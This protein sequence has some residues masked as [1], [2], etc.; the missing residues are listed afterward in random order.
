MARWKYGSD[1]QLY[2]DQ[3]DDGPDQGT[4]SPEQLASQGTSQPTAPTSQPTDW[5][6]YATDVSTSQNP[7]APGGAQYN[8]YGPGGSSDN[9]TGWGD[10][11]DYSAPEAGYYADGKIHTMQYTAAQGAFDDAYNNYWAPDRAQVLASLRYGAG[12]KSVTFD[13]AQRSDNTGI[14]GGA[15][16]QPAQS[17]NYGQAPLG[18]DATKWADP[19]QGTSNKYI[20]GRILAGG[21]TI[22]QA[23]QAVGAKVISPDKIQ[24]PDGFIADV[25]Y[26][27]GGPQ[28]RVQYTQ[29]GGESP[30]GTSGA[31][32]GASGMGGIG[33]AATGGMFGSGASSSGLSNLFGG[34]EAKTL[35]DLLMSRAT[36]S[37]NP[38][39]KNPIIANQV[40]AY[41]AQQQRAARDYID[42]L[43]ESRGPISNLQGEKRLMAEKVGQNVGGFQAQLMQRELDAQRQKI[44]MALS[45]AMGFLTEQQRM[46]LQRESK[47][48]LRQI[49]VT[50]LGP[51]K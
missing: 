41:S 31:A 4:P 36:A 27:F 3:N 51:W 9:R 14:N 49:G 46:A 7:Y 33:A 2:Y 17:T 32:T 24:Y 34:G 16:T 35:Y 26:D 8:P 42:D 25:Y 1:G 15:T 47:C 39:A 48:L 23:A 44:Q 29:V 21:G 50:E 19:A 45:G 5:S 11:R 13:P 37:E 40:N 6:Q 20:V 18:F 30:A 10:E 28:Q 38:D 12:D 43:A 22:E